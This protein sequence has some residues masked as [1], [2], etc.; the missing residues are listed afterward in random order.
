MK[1]PAA[2]AVLI[3]ASLAGCALFQLPPSEEEAPVPAP[4]SETQLPPSEVETPVPSP[5]TGIPTPRRE[6]EQL[7]DYFQRLK[8]LPAAELRREQENARFT[9]D[10][11]R[12]EFDRMRLAMAL[13]LPSSGMNDEA[14][15]LELLDPMVRNRSSPMHG[16]AYMMSAFMQ[17]QRRLGTTVQGMQQKLEALRT[18]ERLLIEREQTGKKR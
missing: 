15:A 5:E 1:T 14:R 6:V 4:E 11:T 3:A 7:L 9:F 10:R 18:M 16:L 17:E 2:C 13:A 8:K 12:S